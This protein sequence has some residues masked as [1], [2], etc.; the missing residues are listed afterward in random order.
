MAMA[1]W[2]P[3]VSGAG[4]DFRG[5]SAGR[6]EGASGGVRNEPEG[7]VRDHEDAGLRE[8]GLGGHVDGEDPRRGAGPDPGRDPVRGDEAGQAAL[9]VRHLDVAGGGAGGDL[10]LDVVVVT[11]ERRVVVQAAQPLERREP[12]DLLAPGRAPGGR[13]GRRSPPGAGGIALD[14]ERVRTAHQPTAPSICSSMSRL[15]S[16][17]YSIGSSLAIGSTKPRTIIAIASSSLHAAR[18][19][20]EELVVGDLRDARLVAHRHVVLADVDVGVGVGA[21][22]LVDQQ[23]V[24][25]HVGL[26]AVGA[27]VDLD[28][29]A[30]RRAPAAARHRLAQ[31]RADDVCGAAC[32]ILAP[33]SWCWPSPAKAIDSVSPLACSPIR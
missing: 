14:L 24:A 17:A 3:A 5:A 9:G 18:H 4:R 11:V 10:D 20:V 22:D 26:R 8:L 6:F 25:Q 32:T 2:R 21:A 23:R 19:Q 12:P 7:W 33:A 30:V 29:P 27:L 1:V 28:Q 13:P 16:R 15:S 31:D